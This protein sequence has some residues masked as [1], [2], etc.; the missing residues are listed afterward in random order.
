MPSVVVALLVFAPALAAGVGVT[1]LSGIALH[2]EERVAVGVPLGA[3]LVGL[4]GWGVSMLIGF[5]LNSLALALF[6]AMAC[7]LPGWARGATS[8]QDDLRD[9]ARRVR[10]PWRDRESLRPLLGLLA[11]AWPLTCASCRSRG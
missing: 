2:L 7:S 6:A 9:V 11:V 8:L 5:S 4:W 10:L 3:L 1:Y